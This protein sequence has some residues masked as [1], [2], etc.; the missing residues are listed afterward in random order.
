[1]GHGSRFLDIPFGSL[2]KDI[3]ATVLEPGVGCRKDLLNLKEGSNDTFSPEFSTR[4]DLKV[5]TLAC[6]PG[7]VGIDGPTHEHVETGDRSNT[8]RGNQYEAVVE[9]P[10]HD[11][12]GQ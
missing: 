10:Y 1:M 6:I 8:G 12:T 4:V 9:T 11:G 2:S 3:Y 5:A 7:K